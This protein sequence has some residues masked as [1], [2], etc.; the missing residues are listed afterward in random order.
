VT[1]GLLIENYG[2]HL[3]VTYSDSPLINTPQHLSANNS[4]TTSHC[5]FV[6]GVEAELRV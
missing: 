1:S 2:C 5:H 3:H 6:E 4:L